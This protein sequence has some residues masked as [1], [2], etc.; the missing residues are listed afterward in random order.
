MLRDR[1]RDY[2]CM[3]NVLMFF[4]SKVSQMGLNPEK[5]FIQRIMG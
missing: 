2:M 3:S 5:E 1:S 4:I